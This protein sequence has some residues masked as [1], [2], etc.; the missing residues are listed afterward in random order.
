MDYG[1]RIEFQARGSPHAH[2]VI[3]VKD[4]P[5]YDVDDNDIVCTFIDQYISCAIPGE[6]GKLKK[7]VQLLRQDKHSSH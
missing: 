3:W 6:E 5:K 1:L 2:C 4:A 7:L